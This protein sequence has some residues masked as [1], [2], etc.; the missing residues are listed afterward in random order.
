MGGRNGTDRRTDASA[1]PGGGGGRAGEPSPRR[2]GKPAAAGQ[3]SEGR[4]RDAGT[5]GH[6]RPPNPRRAK[7]PDGKRSRDPPGARRRPAPRRASTGVVSDRG[8]GPP[9][10]RERRTA[11]RGEEE[12]ALALLPRPPDVNDPSAGS[13]TETLLRLLLPLDSQVRPSS[14]RSARAVGRPR[15]GRSEGLTKPSNR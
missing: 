6:G 11:G 13:P 3:R 2:R 5:Q 7:R 8:R 12:D 14:Q 1:A 9:D 15:R 10:E 4:R